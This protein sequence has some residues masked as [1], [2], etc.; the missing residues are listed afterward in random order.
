MVSLALLVSWSLLPPGFAASPLPDPLPL[1]RVVVP[2]GR[3]AAEL[4]RARQG[5]LIQQPR[6]EF[7]ATVR[8]A[9]LAVQRGKTPPRLVESHYQARLHGT[10]LVGHADWKILNP[11]GATG[12]LPIPN[13]NLALRRAR[14]GA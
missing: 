11:S 4:E 5:V 6:A 1:R 7:E 3:I 14:L 9:A 13:L 10:S 12:I 8:E 2:P